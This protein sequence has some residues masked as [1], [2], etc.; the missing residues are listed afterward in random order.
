MLTQRATADP[1]RR[2]AQPL[3][4]S[5]ITT[6]PYRGLAAPRCQAAAGGHEGLDLSQAGQQASERAQLLLPNQAAAPGIARP[7]PRRSLIQTLAAGAVAATLCPCTAC[8]TAMPGLDFAGAAN[9]KEVAANAPS[10]AWT[11]GAQEGPKQWG[12]MCAGG[13]AQSPVNV[14]LLWAKPSI[15]DPDMP[16]L[17]FEYKLGQPAAVFNTGHGTMQVNVA[18]RQFIA[19]L[20]GRKCE[21]LQFHFHS[22]SEHTFDGVHAP[23]EAH[24]VHRDMETG[25][26]AVVGVMMQRGAVPNPALQW[27]LSYAPLEAGPYAQPRPMVD[28]TSLL[29]RPTN[30]KRRFIHYAGSLTTPPCSEQVSWFVLAD[31]VTVSDQQILDFLLYVG[32]G[33]NMSANARPTQALGERNMN[34]YL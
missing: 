17:D 23:M 34:Y 27:A 31:L 1:F 22:P 20:G 18:G 3:E 4:R 13:L 11:Y 24:L 25:S 32:G 29:P 26:L 14:P 7:M 10:P 5:R 9:A 21:L 6:A 12:G 28:V 8:A 15:P 16:P 19:N 33:R 2:A 30:G